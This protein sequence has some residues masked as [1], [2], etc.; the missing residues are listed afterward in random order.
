MDGVQLIIND[1]DP[2]K[3]KI[4]KLSLTLSL[5]NEKDYEGGDLE[6]DFENT[7]PSKKRDTH[8]CTEIQSKGSLAVF[9]SSVWHRVCPVESGTRYSLVIWSLGWPFK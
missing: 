6:F 3:G 1:G 9:P 8:K 4:R 5:S 7:A 2:L